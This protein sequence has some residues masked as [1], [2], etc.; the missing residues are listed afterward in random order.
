MAT[1]TISFGFFFSDY[2]IMRGSEFVQSSC[3]F[4]L[5]FYRLFN[6][7]KAKKR[8]FR[9]IFT[10]FGVGEFTGMEGDMVIYLT[11]EETK[12]CSKSKLSE[13]FTA[14]ENLLDFLS[15]GGNMDFFDG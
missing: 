15:M 7:G 4:L 11:V 12:I 6:Y 13:F 3:F 14:W 9:N 1:W 5:W 8:H 10:P 2:L